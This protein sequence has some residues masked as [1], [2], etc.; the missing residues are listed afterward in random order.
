MCGLEEHTHTAACLSDVT[1]DVETAADWEVTLP[2]NV[3]DDWAEAVVAI[4]QS[5]LGYSESTL[6]YVLDE[7]GETLRGYTRYGAWAGNEYG[8]WDA[9]FASFCL[10]YAGLS[11]EDFP[12]ATG[13]YA[14]A[15]KLEN[16]GLYAAAA[17]YTPVAGNLVFLDS[18][19][20]GKID[21]VGIVITV[22]EENN[23][24]TVIE[25]IML[26]RTART[27]CARWCMG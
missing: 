12:Q 21:L 4:A 13:A 20:D 16:L 17:D 24:L 10:S 22:D 27:R 6:N 19:A 2:A 14:W 26:L 5:Q 11:T 18:D 15:V 1:A 9:M 7:D 25:G 8:N 3:S 23:S